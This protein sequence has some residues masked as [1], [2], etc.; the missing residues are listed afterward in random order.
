MRSDEPARLD[1]ERIEAA[2]GPADAQA[3]LAPG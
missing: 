3:G 2:P 1:I